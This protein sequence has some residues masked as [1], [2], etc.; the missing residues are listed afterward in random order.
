MKKGQVC[1]PK[2]K[3]KCQLSV[4]ELSNKLSKFLLG[5]QILN[6]IEV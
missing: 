1:T 5:K 4:F 6:V 3:H 2:V